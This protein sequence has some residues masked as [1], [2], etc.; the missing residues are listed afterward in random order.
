MQTINT[1]VL[2]I[3]GGIS[4]LLNAFLLMH[5][6]LEII[7][8]EKN[9][10]IFSNI[11]EQVQDLESSL[12]AT[13]FTARKLEAQEHPSIVKSFGYKSIRKIIFTSVHAVHGF[14]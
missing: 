1:N 8:V 12:Q 11:P 2:I 14:F 7:I 6:D 5:L 9:S 10:L 4:G 13:T 3:G